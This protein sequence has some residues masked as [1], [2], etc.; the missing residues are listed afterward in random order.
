VKPVI[1]DS[2]AEA[3]LAESVAFYEL[4]RR[5]L[6]VEFESAVRAALKRIQ[7]SPELHPLQKNGARKFVMD[8]FPFII[9]YMEL[10]DKIWAVAF[11]HTSRKPGYWLRRI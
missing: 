6:G 1:I 5:G 4:R 9:H 3:E 11:A 2:H 10:P 8:R 7:T